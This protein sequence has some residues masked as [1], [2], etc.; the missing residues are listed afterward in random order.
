MTIFVFVQR[1]T[2]IKGFKNPLPPAVLHTTNLYDEGVGRVS[3]QLADLHPRFLQPSLA[4]DELH[5]VVA[6]LTRAALRAVAAAAQD[7]IGQVVA[8]TGVSRG[9]PL[10]QHRRLVDDRDH[11]ARS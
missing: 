5:A 6:R 11:V 7:V 2:S 3:A 8:V 10:E 9:V 1:V 4:R